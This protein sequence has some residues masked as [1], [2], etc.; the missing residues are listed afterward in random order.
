LVLTRRGSFRVATT[1]PTGRDK[2]EPRSASLCLDDAVKSRSA[3]ERAY[4]E[5]L[6]RHD[7]CGAAR[8]AIQLA[9]YHD[10]YR[11]ESAIA[12]GWLERARSLLDTVP[13]APEH[14]W[15]AFW[16]A[17]L[18][19]HVHGEVAKGEPSL[20]DA[21][22]LNEA[23]NIGGD[24]ALMTRGLRGLMAIS[25]GA[26]D[27]GLRRLDEAMAA[28]ATGFFVTAF[29]LLL[30]E[31]GAI[32]LPSVLAGAFGLP[33]ALAAG[34]VVS[35]FTPAPGRNAIDIVRDMR[36]PG[37]ETIYDREMRLLRLRNRAPS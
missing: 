13:A 27:E 2:Q 10:A 34:I 25:E 20:E 24:L 17:H 37:G 11:G 22:R 21:I 7:F 12:S 32:G 19:I 26:V 29:V 18:D 9:V 4:R 23:G 1:V 16:K 33:L 14:A 8:A 36:V 30:S 31:T 5:Y 28:M 6:E 35:K 3:N 15:L